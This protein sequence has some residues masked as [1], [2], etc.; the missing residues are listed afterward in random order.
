MRLP[1]IELGSYGW[2]PYILPLNYKCLM[3]NITTFHYLP[4]N[5]SLFKYLI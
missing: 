4:L 2:Q 1:R 3:K 5:H